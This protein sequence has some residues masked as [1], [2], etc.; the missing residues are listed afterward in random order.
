MRLAPAH[1]PS[2]RA[3]G[4]D[5]AARDGGAWPRRRP[6][7]RRRVGGFAV[8][9]GALALAAAPASRADDVPTLSEDERQEAIERHAERGWAAYRRGNHEEALTRME[10]LGR[11][12]PE[13]ALPRRLS[14]L[15]K[16]RTGEYEDA[17]RLA[18]EASTAHPED[19]GSRALRY[20]LLR[21]LGRYEQAMTA[22]EAALAEKPDDVIAKTT[23]GLLLD[24]RGRRAE[25]LAQFDGVIEAYN[26]ADP[27][28][29]ELAHV[30]RAVVRA[31]Y[32]SPNPGDD[33]LRDA[34]KLLVR[35]LDAEPGDV[36]ARLLYADVLQ[37]NRGSKS[38]ASATTHYRQ[39]LSENPEVA[40]ARVGLARIA[41]VFY[42]QDEAV[43][44]CRRA[45]ASNP[46]LVSAMNL[47]AHVHVGDGDYDKADAMWSR[48]S[49]VDP[50]D[51]EARSIRAARLFVS[52]DEAG[53]A[54][55]ERGVLEH[56]PTYGRFYAIVATLVGERQRRYDVAAELT[57]KAIAL[58]P[59]DA[60][61][62]VLAGVNLMNLGR[63][64]EAR[65]RFEEAYRV[66][67]GYADVQR[68]NF[69][70]ILDVLKT[71]REAKSP[72][73][74]LR[75][76]SSESAVME[77]YLLPLL[78]E[79]RE[80]LG[81]KYGWRPDGP[82]LVES[83]HR[84][85]DFSVRSI[86]V[87]NIPALGVC[88]G[89]V[90]TLDGPFARP[91]GSFSWA[92]TAWHEYAH[93]VTLGIS[94]GQ[95]PRWLTEGLSV[96][97]EKAHKAEWGREM[98]KELYDRWRNG[99]LLKMADINSA[100]RG[101]D[102]MFA[103]FQGGLIADYLSQ[104]RG[105]GVVPKI[106]ARFAQ[107]VTTER[108]FREELGIEL[109]DFDAKFSEWVGKQ[110][111]GYKMIPTWDDTSRKV[112][113]ELVK[114]EPKN[115]E[116]WIRLAWADLQRG[117]QVDAG[118]SLAEARKL[119][120]DHPE[121]VLL[122]GE[123]A[124]RARR[125]DLAKERFE[126]F[127]ADGHDDLL[128]RL[129]L[130]RIALAAG[131]DSAEAVR[132][133][134]AAKACFPRYVGRGNPYLELVKLHTGAGDVAKA[135]AEMEAY[136]RIA[137]EDFE[138]RKKLAAHYERAGDDAG[139]L[140]VSREMIDIHPFGAD[141]DDPPDLD[142]HRR[143]AEALARAGKTAEALRERKVQ[144][145]LVASL[146][147]AD[148]RAAGGVDAHLAYGEMLLEAGRADDALDQALAALAIDPGSVAARALKE[149]ADPEGSRR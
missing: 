20:E 148:R 107:D 28:P 44:L 144:T 116:A 75:Q 52:G 19:R 79:A 43:D 134:E 51:K 67:R 120:P 18:T 145:L 62:Y 11:L 56:D 149:R 135:V 129:G 92:R 95:V 97:E 82:V 10:R 138:V 63:E 24:D 4:G 29:E 130:S 99:R 80:A 31:H 54:A 122:E 34:L 128:A 118:A 58:D 140:R 30:A 100:F 57:A 40:E 68:E 6:V 110:V 106:L 139:L 69:L 87:Q 123:M 70:G 53:F 12:A 94:E 113:G 72:H 35:R 84:H 115:A 142:L 38:Q 74:V 2:P 8:V 88:F 85:D 109:A 119:A 64:D 66:A 86:G 81:E 17:L 15:V 93:V 89:R 50:L 23:R 102:I 25:A 39:I 117:L 78:A 46:R 114:K 132:Q 126:R 111:G 141:R 83:F 131:G 59:A 13:H 5:S 137:T 48:A 36:D 136:A 7:G 26:H 98:E 37:A 103:Y 96:H 104:T 125:Q 76:H 77:E 41:L 65:S 1:A 105:F 121:V 9:L 22:V 42:D 32:L 49:A 101:P 45:L 16:T 127:L 27:D 91:L 133:L 108:V 3:L 147:E 33:L 71:F 60:S 124:L 55:I 14:A 146:P 112:F 143:Y 90:I 61:T 47:L 21:R 73:F